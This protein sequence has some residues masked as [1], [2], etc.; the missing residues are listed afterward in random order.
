M[1]KERLLKVGNMILNLYGFF[2]FSMC[3]FVAIRK[4][5]A[6]P[7]ILLA[8]LV[9][10]C[11]YW[12]LRKKWRARKPVLI[13]VIRGVVLGFGLLAFVFVLFLTPYFRCFNFAVSREAKEYFQQHI[14][15]DEIEYK[16]V[17][18]IRKTPYMDYQ[19]VTAAIKYED[20]HTHQTMQREIVLYFDRYENKYF[21][22]FEEMRQYRREN[23]ATYF[24]V[25]SHLD[26]KEIN[27]RIYE[28]IEYVAEGNYDGIWPIVDEGCKASLTKE[29]RE[30]WQQKLA[31]LGA[32][33]QIRNFE[34]P[35]IEDDESGTQKVTVLVTAGF[36]EG[37]AEI[38]LVI[39]E[40][41]TI[42]S[43]EVK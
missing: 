34:V 41:L 14:Q 30:A 37:E 25:T 5:N 22:T 10:P 20:R 35:L 6:I 26:E 18:G 15:T 4:E 36:A 39:D 29:K 33:K 7:P 2:L 17:T 1:K 11:S 24:Y 9:C 27:K 43:M 23:A 19:E 32:Y 16:E 38:E 42:L 13:R 21:E 40:E 3:V 28:V 12:F 31:P 8:V